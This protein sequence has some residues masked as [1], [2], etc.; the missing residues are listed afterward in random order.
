VA[1]S[2]ETGSCA[3]K[4]KVA[5]S[6][7]TRGQVDQVPPMLTECMKSG[8]NREESLTAY[9]LLIQA[10]LFDDEQ[11][12]ADSTMLAFLNKN[13][14]YELS[15]T[16][17]S[18]FVN[19]FNTF[20]VKPLVQ[21]S[22]HLGT[23]VPFLTFV[24]ENSHS[25]E[26]VKS[27]YNM[28]AVNLFASVEAKFELS[29]KLEFNV[30][31][32][33]SQLSFTNVE[34]FMGFGESSYKETLKRI[35]LPVSITY[36]LMRFN[37]LTLYGRLGLGPAFTLGSTAKV[38]FNPTDTNNPY[39]RT[40]TDIDRKDSRIS[41]DLFSQL[42]AGVKYKTPGGYL[43]AELRSNVGIFNQNVKGGA[44]S[45][46]PDYHYFSSDNDF[47]F[48][49]LNISVGYTQLFYKPSKRKE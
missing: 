31:A 22:V 30:E 2:Q 38:E 11:D 13:S 47:R 33:Y 39:E 3:E 21:I 23:N 28:E 44:S 27:L 29:K 10:Y 40:G 1:Y 19:L 46:E 26:P 7:F 9:K 41:M 15:P 42:G 17:H 37:K 43:I 4:L 45:N 49:S 36:N 18:S 20:K 16:D 8:F 35:E 25:S 6:L 5:E 12:L 34:T 24:D 14:E 48:N 32:G